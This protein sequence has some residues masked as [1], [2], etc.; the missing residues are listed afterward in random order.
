MKKM[1]SL[2]L[3]MSFLF[4]CSG[5]L[6]L[7]YTGHQGNEP[8][9]ELLEETRISGPLAVQNLETNTAK[10]FKS[11]PVLDN[12]PTDTTYVYRSAN[13]YGGRA[14]ARQNTNLVVFIEQ[15]FESK[16][17][18]FAYLREQG[19]ITIADEAIG[20][21][22]LVTPA[23]RIAF[24]A[25]DQQNYYKLQTA[26]F[27]QKASEIGPDGIAAVNDDGKPIAY[28]DAEYFGGY[29]FYYVIGKDGGATF[30]NNYVS[31]VPD[32]VSRIG[33]M[34]LVG[35]EMERIR[36]VAGYIPAY[37][38]NAPESVVTKYEAANKVDAV[39]V[40]GNKTTAYCQAF[41]SRR[42]VTLETDSIDT[43]ALIRDAYYSL[44]VKTQRSQSTLT[45][46]ISASTPF[47]GYTQDN[48]PYSLMPR[49]ALIN[50]RT[51]DGIN[52]F[53]HQEDRFSSIKTEPS[54][55]RGVLLPGG[56][57]LETW[58]E[59]LPDE[60]LDHTADP[61]SIPLLVLMHGGGDDPR[62]YVEE[63]G[64]LELMGAERLAAVAMEH[65]YITDIV[66]D[67][68]P[69]L[70]KYMI[71]TYPELDASRVYVTGYSMGG[72]ATYDAVL[73]DAS[74]FAAAVPQ[75]IIQRDPTEVQAA[76]FKELDI[77]L[78]CTTSEYDY[79]VDPVTHNLP[80]FYLGQ[81][82]QFLGFNELDLLVLESLDYETYPIS[83]FKAD[84]YKKITLNDEFTNHTWLFVKD[85]IPMAGVNYT[86]N[87]IH[88]LYAE[89][90]NV[91]WDFCKHYSR[92]VATGAVI[93]DPYVR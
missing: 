14:S 78:M 49:N 35:G 67:C 23:D 77:P 1:L 84:I 52:I 9:F 74:L 81:L 70:V 50:G 66:D 80:A 36:E 42:V 58:Y 93:Y 64:Y 72:W 43:T 25:A 57:Y 54:E 26:M 13:L 11:H 12:Y 65:Q 27:A 40:E 6:A 92:D 55:S 17:E 73:G 20:S 68:T 29:S 69:L 45:G 75:A 38:V 18:A 56:E 47:Q 90:A 37:L 31:S 82:N 59:Y 87:N 30:L 91:V 83:G 60:V 79:F 19:L 7:G 3:T 88:A 34:L 44:F 85:G 8:T 71:E 5:A 21:I 48:A 46:M 53:T 15:A 39:L 62:L 16:D 89:Y 2:L 32:Y 86:E 22:V 51:V 28:S 63:Q 4:S 10:V 24:G 61:G 76:Q 41:P 33:A